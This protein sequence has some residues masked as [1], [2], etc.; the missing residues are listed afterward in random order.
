MAVYLPRHE[1]SMLFPYLCYWYH[2]NRTFNEYINSNLI[3]VVSV[4]IMSVSAIWECLQWIVQRIAAY[5][6]WS[7]GTLGENTA[8]Y[9]W[10]VACASLGS[11]GMSWPTKAAWQTS[12]QLV[13]AGVHWE[14]NT[15]DVFVLMKASIHSLLDQGLEDMDLVLLSI[16]KFEIEQA[17]HVG[18]ILQRSV[19]ERSSWMILLYFGLCYISRYGNGYINMCFVVI[20]IGNE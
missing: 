11:T 18:K 12:P 19:A 8:S 13:Q 6:S 1:I 7:F 2:I 9:P 17:A 5:N 20:T 4:R 14:R 16:C 3:L 15:V 10:F